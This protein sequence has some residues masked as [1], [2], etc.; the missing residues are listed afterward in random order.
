MTQEIFPTRK[1]SVVAREVENE[2]ILYDPD[3]KMVYV[4][5]ATARDIWNLC[6]GNHDL[7]QI[8][9]K[10]FEEYDIEMGVLQKD[11]PM[12]VSDLNRIG[13]L[14]CCSEPRT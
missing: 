13:L 8:A 3:A 2:C 4:L 1:T 11:I 7:E 10:I 5:N 12:I 14:S 9:L 6:D